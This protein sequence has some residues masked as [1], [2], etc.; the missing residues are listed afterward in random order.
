M[1]YTKVIYY[2]FLAALL[3][4]YYCVPG[5][6]RWCVLLAGSMVFYW[7]AVRNPLL[8]GAFLAM[9]ALSYGFGLLIE[10]TKS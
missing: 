4:V 3:F 10:R 9:I 2:P 8:T 7:L 6:I 1:N 5:K